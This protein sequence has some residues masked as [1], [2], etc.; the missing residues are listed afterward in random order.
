MSLVI[1]PAV[2]ADYPRIRYIRDTT[3]E[4]DSSNAIFIEAQRRA[5]RVPTA[6]ELVAVFDGVII[7][8]ILAGPVPMKLVAQVPSEMDLGGFALVEL[9]LGVLPEH[10]SLRVGSQL[11]EREMAAGRKLGFRICIALARSPESSQF[12]QKNHFMPASSLGVKPGPM[13]QRYVKQAWFIETVDALFL[14]REL[15]EVTL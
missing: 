7:G 12:F 5:G 3:L 10:R 15:R 14:I 4:A 13:F 8:T 9:G 11:L 2:K 6:L 1:R